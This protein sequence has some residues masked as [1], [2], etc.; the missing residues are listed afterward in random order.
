MAE[1][2]VLHFIPCGQPLPFE[3]ESVDSFIIGVPETALKKDSGEFEVTG[4]FEAHDP[5][6]LASLSLTDDTGHVTW[7]DPPEDSP[8]TRRLAYIIYKYQ[9][10]DEPLLVTLDFWDDAVILD[11]PEDMEDMF[12][13]TVNP[14]WVAIMEPILSPLSHVIFQTLIKDVRRRVNVL[15]TPVH[16]GFESSIHSTCDHFDDQRSPALILRWAVSH[17]N[18]RVVLSYARRPDMTLDCKVYEEKMTLSGL[19]LFTGQPVTIN[20]L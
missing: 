10:I 11:F 19:S 6:L 8:K 12:D 18:V 14:M 7:F 2:S 1:E 5:G 4:T 17:A 15:Y 3:S 20:E 13:S 16:G 9:K